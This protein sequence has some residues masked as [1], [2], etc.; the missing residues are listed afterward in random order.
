MRRGAPKQ[1]RAQRL[2]PLVQMGKDSEGWLYV[3]DNG[4]GPYPGTGVG[5]SIVRRLLERHGGAIHA[6]S[7]PGQ[8]STFRF[9]FGT[10]APG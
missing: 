6:E 9:R 2:Q 4:V 8:G 3:R 10:R 1:G 7:Q 5:L